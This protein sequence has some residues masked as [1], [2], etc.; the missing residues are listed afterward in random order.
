MLIA[1]LDGYIADEGGRFDWD[2]PDPEVHAFINDL[3]RDFD[4]EAVGRLKASADRDIAVGGPDL[5]Y[6]TRT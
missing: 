2:E 4:P 1:S 3:E 6:R 5:H